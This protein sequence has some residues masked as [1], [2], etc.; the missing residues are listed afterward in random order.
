[1]KTRFILKA[2]L[3]YFLCVFAVGF[4]L[5]PL[6]ELWAIP[7]FGERLGELLEMPFMLLAM[8]LVARFVIRRF[9]V[10]LAALPRLAIGLIAL[11]CLL[12]AELGVVFWIRGFTLADYMAARDPVSGAVY[13]AMLALLALM[14]L[15]LRRRH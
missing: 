12:L 10:P 14:P 8:V 7:R 4:A 11:A 15:L 6:R 2:G 5:A 13:L 3:T 9:R 1:M